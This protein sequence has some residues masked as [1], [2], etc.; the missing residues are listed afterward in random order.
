M[1]YKTHEIINQLK[2]FMWEKSLIFNILEE[3]VL[4]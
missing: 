1:Y 3:I 4:L 2:K